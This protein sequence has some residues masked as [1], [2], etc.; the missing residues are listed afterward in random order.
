MTWTPLAEDLAESLPEI[1]RSAASLS[2]AAWA[3]GVMPEAT[4]GLV[5]AALTLGAQVSN[6]YARSAPL[7]TD[8]DM[9]AASQDL[10]AATAEMLRHAWDLANQVADA[11]EEAYAALAAASAAVPAGASEQETA[12]AEAAA[13]AAR[14]EAMMR[15][16]DCDTALDILGPV[17]ARLRYALSCLSCVPDDLE[18]TYE[19]PY[20][21]VRRGGALPHEGEWLTGASPDSSRHA[22]A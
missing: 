18:T 12:D 3:A 19:A 22:A 11:L 10:E 9:L 4:H 7:R 13:E 16:A 21:L 20:E 2:A 6:L 15:I 17:L 5:G 1:G 8:Q 14:A